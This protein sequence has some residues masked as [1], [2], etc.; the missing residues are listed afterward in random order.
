MLCFIIQESE[1]K[2]IWQTRCALVVCQLSYNIPEVKTSLSNDHLLGNG[3]NLALILCSTTNRPLF[4]VWLLIVRD[5]IKLMDC[6]LMLIEHWTFLS[7]GLRNMGVISYETHRS[8]DCTFYK[9]TKFVGSWIIW[10]LGNSHNW[11][12]VWDY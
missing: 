12:N 10:A 7:G 2:R 4:H 5:N 3:W 9:L 11:C 6:L 8:R 1:V